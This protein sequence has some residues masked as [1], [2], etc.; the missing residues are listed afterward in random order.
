MSIIP[1]NLA[2]STQ[3]QIGVGSGHRLSALDPGGSNPQLRNP[4]WITMNPASGARI[5]PD[6][7]SVRPGTGPYSIPGRPAAARRDAIS[8][9][10]APA[11]SS[12]T[13]RRG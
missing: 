9:C 3:V 4:F 13:A 12:D 1:D 11:P 10:T 8:R 7:A 2:P 5:N 6:P